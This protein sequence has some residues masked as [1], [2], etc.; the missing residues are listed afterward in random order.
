VPEVFDP[1]LA[2][3]RLLRDTLVAHVGELMSSVEEPSGTR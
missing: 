2:G 3:S 1:E